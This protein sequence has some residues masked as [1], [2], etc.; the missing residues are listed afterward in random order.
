MSEA[1]QKLTKTIV[2]SGVYS[3]TM[4]RATSNQGVHQDPRHV[5]TQ[6]KIKDSIKA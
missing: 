4:N 5:D 2:A 6:F 1:V 3:L